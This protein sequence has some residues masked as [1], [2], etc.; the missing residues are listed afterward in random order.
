ML[1][2]ILSLLSLVR[3]TELGG[4]L[5][6][7]LKKYLRFRGAWKLK[8]VLNHTLTSDYKYESSISALGSLAVGSCFSDSTVS[9]DMQ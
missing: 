2:E 5:A 1:H 3:D 8:A 4:I 7:V 9:D 6:Q